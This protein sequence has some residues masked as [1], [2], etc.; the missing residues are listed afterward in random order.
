MGTGFRSS[1]IADWIGKSVGSSSGGTIM[2]ERCEGLMM[3]A[4]IDARG[5]LASAR[6][7][8]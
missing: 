3:M 1:E 8:Q 4:V 6:I 2:R 7:E 5:H